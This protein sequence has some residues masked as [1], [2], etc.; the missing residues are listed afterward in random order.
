MD[1]VVLGRTNIKASKNGFGALPI[2][3]ISKDEATNLLQKAYHNGMNFFDTARSYSNSEEKI[4]HA[5]SHVRSHIFISTKTP[6]LC[7]EDFWLDLNTS[8]RLLNTDYIDILQFHNPPFC[9]KPDGED[10]LYNAM[11][12]F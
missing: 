11:C 12:H 10:G 3:R 2:Q 1:F 8:L 6:A 4:G 5:L 9:P 7:A